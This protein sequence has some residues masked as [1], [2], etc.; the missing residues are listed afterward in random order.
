MRG[1][2]LTEASDLVSSIMASPPNA[3]EGIQ[4][5]TPEVESVDL[6]RPTAPHAAKVEALPACPVHAGCRGQQ[7]EGSPAL[8]QLLSR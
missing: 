5:L 6:A 4:I 2:G 7:E 1:G 3:L 8:H